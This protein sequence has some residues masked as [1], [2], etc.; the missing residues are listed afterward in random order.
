MTEQTDHEMIVQLRIDYAVLNTKMNAAI[1]LGSAS[2]VGL[3][4]LII[5]LGLKVL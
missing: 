5:G 4:T 1:F 2:V 3:I